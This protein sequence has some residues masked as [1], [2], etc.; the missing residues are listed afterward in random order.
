VKA[1]KQ[2][3]SSDALCIHIAGNKK[4]AEPTTLV[5]DLPG[6]HVEVSRCSDNTYWVHVE[7]V[8]NANVMEGRI[9]RS[10]RVQ[11][12]EEMPDASTVTKLA[13]RIANIVPRFNPDA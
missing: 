6:G 11:A 9:Q 8:N 5:I 7:V 12:V 4:Q 3:R 2:T 10:D 13:I 1:F